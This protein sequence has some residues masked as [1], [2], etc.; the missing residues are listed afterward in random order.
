MNEDD[1]ILDEH[2]LREAEALARALERG[3]ADGELP[4]DALSAA[5]L[6]R[7]GAGG[8]VLR[9]ER[10]DAVLEEVLAA[11]D[12]V[13]ERKAAPSSGVPFWRWLFGAAGLAAAVALVLLIVTG[14]GEAS[15]TALPAPD[16]RL[17]EAQ[18]ARLG[19]PAADERF[20]E[21]MRGYRGDVYAALEARYGSR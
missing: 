12:R 2:E 16:A 19:D 21:A 11:A 9:R 1:P 13:R 14:P 7:Y 5:A 4:D 3:S 15:P 10:E 18:L 17:I 6:I 20:D 8:G